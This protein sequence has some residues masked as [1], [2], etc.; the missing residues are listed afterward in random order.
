[1]RFHPFSPHPTK[2]RRCP[3]HPGS[4]LCPRLKR[5]S[6]RLTAI[7]VAIAALLPTVFPFRAAA[8]FPVG[9]VLTVTIES[10][11]RGKRRF[12]FRHEYS[13]DVFTARWTRSTRYMRGTFERFGPEVLKPGVRAEVLYSTPAFGDP[14]VARVFLLEPAPARRPSK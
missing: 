1:M 4:A 6:H 2:E 8:S 11:D 3:S 7:A 5:L 10:V 13:G 9:R 12:T 14:F